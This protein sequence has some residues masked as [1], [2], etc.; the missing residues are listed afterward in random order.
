MT[1]HFEAAVEMMAT[2]PRFSE[3]AGRLATELYRQLAE[4]E[5]VGLQN[6]ASALEGTVDEIRSLLESEEL[7]GWVFYDDDARVI[8]F[9]GLAVRRMPHRFDVE[10][11]GLY[12]W[13]GV[14]SLFIPPII[15]K[16][17]H[18]ETK[19]PRTGRVIRL[20]VTPEGVESCDPPSTVMSYLVG[21]RE[22]V[23]TNPEKVMAAFCHH[24]FF[25]ESPEVGA[26]WAAEH[27]HGAFVVSL[28]QAFELGRL[29]NAAQS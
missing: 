9:R 27:G 2:L 21:D 5:P 17:A 3:A 25:L 7:K 14:D 8:G 28:D 10:G 15:D 22:V 6:L 4:G 18:V 13:C 19:D 16:S 11:K 23:K 26:A 12:T 20:I 1:A 29:F 24:I